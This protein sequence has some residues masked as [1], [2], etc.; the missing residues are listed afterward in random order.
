[1]ERETDGMAADKVEL[2]EALASAIR[3]SR[4]YSPSRRV[5][6]GET[7]PALTKQEEQ[8]IAL[9]TIE[10]E[11]VY[12]DQQ[13]QERLKQAHISFIVALVMLILGIL[14]IL[15]GVICM[16]VI[17]FPAGAATSV[18]SI[19]VGSISALAF[20]FKKDIDNR[21]DIIIKDIN[22]L[23]KSSIAMHYIGFITDLDA[24]DKAIRDL[25]NRLYDLSPNQKDTKKDE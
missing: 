12:I 23:E 3:S 10:H 21:L 1:M 18:S 11:R 5:R 20:K 19:V 14:L 22:T 15:T 8:H 6:L 9:R 13:H 24:K 7:L 25:I 16:F 2:V 17:S 4:I